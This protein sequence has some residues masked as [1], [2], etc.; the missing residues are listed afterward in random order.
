MGRS[1]DWKAADPM[2]VIPANAGTH[3]PPAGAWRRTAVAARPPFSEITRY[4]SRLSPGRRRG[5][6]P[7]LAVFL[8]RF[9]AETREAFL[10]DV[11]LADVFAAFL[12]RARTD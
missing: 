2:N 6:R 7:R 5:H 3:K 10:A 8:L 1:P 9:L 4:W 12:D 11:F